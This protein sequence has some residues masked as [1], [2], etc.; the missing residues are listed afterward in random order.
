MESVQSEIRRI[1][2][3]PFGD[4]LSA[5]VRRIEWL[6]RR[7]LGKCSDEM[8]TLVSEVLAYHIYASESGLHKSAEHAAI[9]LGEEM[10]IALSRKN[11]F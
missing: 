8:S 3:V 6:I 7:R 1:R 5:D 9:S 2:P 4:D 11:R 10:R